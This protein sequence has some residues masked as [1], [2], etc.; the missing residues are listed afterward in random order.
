MLDPKIIDS[1][2]NLQ[3][4]N[5][6]GWWE[7]SVCLFATIGL[8]S[9]WYHIGKKQQDLGQVWLALSV[10]CWSL[11]GVVEVIFTNLQLGPWLE[12]LQNSSNLDSTTEILQKTQGEL[13]AQEQLLTNRWNGWRSIFSL[14]NSLFVLLALPWFRYIPASIKP[15]ITSKYWMLIVGLPFLFSL[16]PTISKMFGPGIN[17]FIS[18]LDVY[19]SVLTLIFL[20]IVMWSSFARRRL[21]VLAWLSLV[22]IFITFVAQVYKMLDSDINLILFSAIFKSCL[23]MIFFALALSWVKELSENTIDS[24]GALYLSIFQQN[25]HGRNK[26]QVQLK[27][28]AKEY[29]VE[30]T[31]TYYSLLRTFVQKKKMEDDESTW[32]EIK[33]KNESRDGKIYEIQDYNQVKRLT[34]TILDGMYGKGNWSN[35]IHAKGLKE[36]LFEKSEKYPRLIRLKVPKENLELDRETFT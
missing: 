24:R 11:S 5:F 23:I 35:E 1:I 28:G 15:I 34:N 2:S 26:Q 14:F 31:E 21:P 4:L 25:V 7:F 29:T 32:L 17:S 8:L 22:C 13:I 6:Y 12:F 3:L 30:L 19:Y 20:G 36:T 9:I 10:L 18:E 27:I 33:P 16:L